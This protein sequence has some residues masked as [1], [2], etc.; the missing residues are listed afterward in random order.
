MARII[1]TYI[2]VLLLVSLGFFGVWAISAAREL[3]DPMQPPPFA[4]QKIRE[5]ER[6]AN[7]KPAKPVVA[8]PEDRAATPQLDYVPRRCRP[9][10][11]SIRPER[12]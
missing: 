8:K 10:S 1:T 4:L 2:V 7:P 12:F 3:R 6:A 9:A 11:R 5:A